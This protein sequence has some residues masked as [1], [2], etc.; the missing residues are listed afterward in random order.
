MDWP[1]V[2]VKVAF[3]ALMGSIFWLDLDEPRRAPPGHG[4][5]RGV[6]RDAIRPPAYPGIPMDQDADAPHGAAQ[7]EE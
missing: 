4:F 2:A 7:G 3:F 5:R 1:D 6:L